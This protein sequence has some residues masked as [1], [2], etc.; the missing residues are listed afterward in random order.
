[1]ENMSKF[2][3]IQFINKINKSNKKDSCNWIWNFKER[4]Y[5]A[6][7]SVV[8]IYS[9]FLHFIWLKLNDVPPW[10]D[11]I[12]RILRSMDLFQIWEKSGLID[13]IKS[14]FMFSWDY[15]YPPIVEFGYLFYSK[16]AGIASEMELLMNSLYL[17][18]GMAGIYGIG[19]LFFNKNTGILA[20]L[21]FSSFPGILF[22]SKTGFREFQMACFLALTLLFLFKTECLRNRK[23]SIL[24]A[25]SFALT[26]LIKLESLIFLIFPLIIEGVNSV[27]IK[28]IFKSRYSIVNLLL[29]L[30]IFSFIF[31][32]WHVK[33]SFIYLQY[34]F[35]LH[36]NLLGKFYCVLF[37]SLCAY[38]VI[39]CLKRKRE[40]DAR[41]VVWFFLN[42]LCPFL[43]FSFLYPKNESHILSLLVF[44][45]LIIAGGCNAVRGKLAKYTLVL[46]VVLYSLL[47]PFGFLE[48]VSRQKI[49]SFGKQILKFVNDDYCNANVNSYISKDILPC[50]FVIM[51]QSPLGYFQMEYYKKKMKLPLKL[52][53]IL[54]DCKRAEGLFLQNKVDY[55]IVEIPQLTH[56]KETF[57]FIYSDGDK[58]NENYCLIRAF[59]LPNQ[60]EPENNLKVLIYK[61]LTKNVKVLGNG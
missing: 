1:M 16:L 35:S 34:L 33:N 48:D 41:N 37:I 32:P 54:P 20:A 10:G 22:Y 36:F 17:G 26:M 42:F 51:N 12:G 18:I 39:Q 3:N 52:I 14:L 25:I 29:I 46:G 61:R 6:V 5:L 55:L 23:F 30:I 4:W 43:I 44:V 13:F 40:I 57:E 7:L 49:G 31:F 38:S 2:L 59:D 28:K 56:P 11:A 9:T 27:F 53:F 60:L 19:K 15:P 58:F 21:M 24:F 8:W 47:L 45:S 50:V